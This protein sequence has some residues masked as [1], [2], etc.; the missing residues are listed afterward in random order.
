MVFWLN[1]YTFFHTASYVKNP[2]QKSGG[3]NSLMVKILKW[4]VQQAHLGVMVR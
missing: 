3:A 1:M 2:S 4:G